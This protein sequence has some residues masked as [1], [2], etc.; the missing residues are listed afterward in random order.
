[1][2]LDSFDFLLDSFDFL[3]FFLVWRQRRPPV[4][5]ATHS[6][7]RTRVTKEHLKLRPRTFD[8]C[9]CLVGVDL[10]S[11]VGVHLLSNL[12]RLPW[13]KMQE[14][15]KREWVRVGLDISVV[16]YKLSILPLQVYSF[17]LAETY[18]THV[19]RLLMHGV[20]TSTV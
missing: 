7:H 3:V 1:M 17:F 4:T 13:V 20:T 12:G 11:V 10:D 5:V 18:T 15:I 16:V 19:H 8:S 9:R 6:V 2:L 14:R